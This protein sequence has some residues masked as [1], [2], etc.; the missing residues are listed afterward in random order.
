MLD[1]KRIK[2]NAPKGATHFSAC[3][4][5]WHAAYFEIHED[6][7]LKCWICYEDDN[8]GEFQGSISCAYDNAHTKRNLIDLSEIE[9]EPN[10]S[11]GKTEVEWDGNGIPPVGETVLAWNSDLAH[12]SWFTVEILK[13]HKNG[14]A[15]ACFI[16]DCEECNLGWFSD[17][18]PIPKEPSMKDKMLDKWR[19]R[20]LDFAHDTESSMYGLGSVF[21]FVLKNF[22]VEEKE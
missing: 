14:V 22:N 7:A 13:H 15:A 18:K 9:E 12:G 5:K 6:K 16:R 1:L 19:M 4:D 21:N 11:L 17:F 10:K 8:H 20:S 2:A 3:D